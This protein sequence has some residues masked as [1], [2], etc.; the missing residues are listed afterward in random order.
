MAV[1]HGVYTRQ[2]WV[3]GHLSSPLF[4]EFIAVFGCRGRSIAQVAGRG[5]SC[6]LDPPRAR[7]ADEIRGL[8]PPRFKLLPHK[9]RDSIRQKSMPVSREQS[10][11]RIEPRWV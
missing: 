9:N 8:D 1:G 10:E 11:H 5:A 3:D 4:V 6:G 2:A 7:G